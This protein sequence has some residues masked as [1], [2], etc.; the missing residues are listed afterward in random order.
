MCIWRD[1]C[2]FYLHFFLAFYCWYCLLC[3]V[4]VV[5]LFIHLNQHHFYCHKLLVVH[6]ISKY[7]LP[8]E[9]M[10]LSK[11]GKKSTKHCRRRSIVSFCHFCSVYLGSI[12][13]VLLADKIYAFSMV[14][15]FIPLYY[16]V[17][18]VSLYL[19]HLCPLHL[20]VLYIYIY[21]PFVLIIFLVAFSI[22]VPYFLLFHYIINKKPK[23]TE[24][25]EAEKN[26]IRWK[27]QQ[28][29]YNQ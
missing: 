1:F 17:Y 8:S 18:T 22:A 25:W 16:T 5:S 21:L 20:S 27:R 10:E 28:R 11:R 23:W 2:W 29:Q 13:C 12:P 19:A 24:S 3:I 6:L 26:K 9:A 14:I 7:I 15:Q 4:V